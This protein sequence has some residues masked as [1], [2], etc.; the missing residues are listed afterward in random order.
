MCGEEDITYDGK[1]YTPGDVFS[2]NYS[3]KTEQSTILTFDTYNPMFHKFSEPKGS[4]NVSGYNSDYEFVFLRASENQDTIVLR[5]KKYGQEMTMTRLEESP[6]KYME[7]AATVLKTS[8]IIQACTIDGNSYHA[9][10]EGRKFFITDKDST[11][12][13][14]LIIINNNDL[15]LR[16]EIILAN[17]V[18]LK[19]FRLEKENKRFVSHDERAVMEYPSPFGQ[20]SI[21]PWF[22]YVGYDYVDMSE[23]LFGLFKTGVHYLG[24]FGDYADFFFLGLKG[25]CGLMGK[26]YKEH[27]QFLG[28]VSLQYFFVT[29]YAESMLAINFVEEDAGNSIVRIEE[30]DRC[31]GNNVILD[32]GTRYQSFYGFLDGFVNNNPYKVTYDDDTV[33][34]VARF[35][36]VSNP[37]IWFIFKR[38][39]KQQGFTLR[40]FADKYGFDFY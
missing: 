6:K 27:H 35:E 24:S 19:S 26:K 17:N 25:S 8:S 23:E 2:S 4:S 18:H 20:L 28:F 37:N 3:V 31:S 29:G 15:I 13:E 1:T 16:N 12:Y 10:V 36:S 9:R 22:I 32:D 21:T 34:S 33:P 11:E 40:Q 38:E 14:S 39:N 5:G 30:L 7:E